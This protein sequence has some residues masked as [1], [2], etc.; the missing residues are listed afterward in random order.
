MRQAAIKAMDKHDD[1]IRADAIKKAKEKL[2]RAGVKIPKLT[3]V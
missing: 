3:N 2:G 1:G